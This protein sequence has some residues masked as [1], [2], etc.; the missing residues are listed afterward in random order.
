MLL[1]AYEKSKDGY[2]S[3][4]AA[5][6][7]LLRIVAWTVRLLQRSSRFLAC[8]DPVFARHSTITSH[9]PRED[10]AFDLVD[11]MEDVVTTPVLYMYASGGAWALVD[12][13]SQGKIIQCR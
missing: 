5:S 6:T 1:T 8:S 4:S 3:D 13:F 9:R 10:R 7:R 11:G 12:S 2:G